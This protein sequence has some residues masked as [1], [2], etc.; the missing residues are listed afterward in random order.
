MLKKMIGWLGL[1]NFMIF[2]TVFKN[3]QKKYRYTKYDCAIV[4]GYPANDNGKPSKIMKTRVDKAVELYKDGKIKFIILSGGSVKNKYKEADV[5]EEY[6]L[7]SGVN[8]DIIFKE[9]KAMCTYHNLMYTKEIMNKNHLKNCLV[10]TNSWHLR[11]ADHYARKFKFDYAMISAQA[12]KSYS[13][14][15]II[16][17]HISTNLKMYFNLFKGYH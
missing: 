15:K 2:I 9:D 11:K 4:C 12:P 16:I 6:A 5:M 3:P 8:Q 1:I 13:S 14:L 17:L 7:G 10:V